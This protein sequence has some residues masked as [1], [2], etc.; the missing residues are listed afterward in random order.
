M[1]PFVPV[2]AYYPG[3]PGALPCN[4]DGIPQPGYSLPSMQMGVL[5]CENG[6]FIPHGLTPQGKLNMI[7]AVESHIGHWTVGHR[8][9]VVLRQSIDQTKF[10]RLG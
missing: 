7:S 3:Y 9:P 5:N 6:A 8:I 1:Q 2:M 4:Q 10:S